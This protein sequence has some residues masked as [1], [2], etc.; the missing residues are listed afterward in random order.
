MTVLS[1]LL[2]PLWEISAEPIVVTGNEP[3][4]DD[5][6]ILYINQAFTDMT[7]Y[8][9]GEAVGQ[10]WSMLHGETT[11]HDI[12]RSSEEQLQAGQLRE[13]E[14]QH[15]RKNGSIYR[16]AITRAPLVDLDGTSEY[17]ISMYKMLPEHGS[18]AADVQQ[19]RSVPLTIPMPLREF[20]D[21]KLP[22]HLQS[23]S[24][25]D[26]LLELWQEV[27]DAG[28]LPNRGDFTLDIMKQWAPH[29]SIAL[30]LPD[31]R[32]Q[33][34]LFGSELSNVYGRD[35][36][37]FF[38]DELTPHDLWSVVTEHYRAVIKTG[39]PLFAPISVSNGRWYNEVSRLLLPLSGNDDVNFV[40]GADY[41]RDLRY[42]EQ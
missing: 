30:A 6:S 14:L 42:Y 18:A 15:Y 22:Q 10:S 41:K 31:G 4:P 5:R 27:R 38:I 13:Y 39:E 26:S 20:P 29:L 1:R 12:I 36:T 33:F 21:G 11:D 40:M 3:N 32:F 16:C 28:A 25:L 24:E 17:L 9:S 7:G 37:G 34:R 2:Q 8:S 23:H 19:N 35:L